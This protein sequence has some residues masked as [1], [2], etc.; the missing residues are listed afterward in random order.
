MVPVSRT[1]FPT[2][3]AQPRVSL[4]TAAAEWTPGL[5]PRPAASRDLE[6]I[7]VYLVLMALGAILL[8]ALITLPAAKSG[9]VGRIVG[10]VLL[11]LVGTAAAVV[12]D[13]SGVLPQRVSTEV[14]GEHTRQVIIDTLQQETQMQVLE[15][16]GVEELADRGV[17]SSWVLGGQQGPQEVYCVTVDFPDSAEMRCW[18]GVTVAKGVTVDDDDVTE[19]EDDSEH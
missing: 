9:G 19:H 5:D 16:P 4:H 13:H 8:A 1:T 10:F 14:K 12:V 6:G 17:P 3:G 11:A 2:D 7:T 15:A 18:S